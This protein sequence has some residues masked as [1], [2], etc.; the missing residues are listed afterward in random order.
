M[1][2]TMTITESTAAVVGSAQAVLTERRGPQGSWA[3]RRRGSRLTLD[4][5][6][7]VYGLGLNGRIFRE[8][9]R[10]R[11]VSA[12]GALLSLG[13]EVALEQMIVL[14]CKR[15]GEE[16]RCRVV[17]REVAKGKIYIGVAF[18]TPSPRFWGV[19][20][21]PDDWDRIDSKTI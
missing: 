10:T 1:A 5:A 21:P 16:M 6:V 20:F 2:T 19:T 12:Y 9:A 17:Y 14:V 4:V 18:M 11:V 8:E 7:E 15:N 3:P 13:A